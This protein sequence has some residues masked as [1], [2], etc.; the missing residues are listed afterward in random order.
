MEGVERVNSKCGLNFWAQTRVLDEVRRLDF[1]AAMLQHRCDAIASLQQLIL[2]FSGS[3]S[4]AVASQLC[5][6]IAVTAFD[7]LWLPQHS[8]SI[9]AML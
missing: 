2:H 6:S 4:M 3:R 1:D 9:A 8:C 5:Y 7:A